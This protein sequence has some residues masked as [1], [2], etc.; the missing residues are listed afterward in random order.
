MVNGEWWCA[1][2]HHHRHFL[3]V[4][5]FQHGWSGTGMTSLDA[6]AGPAGS[7]IIGCWCL[8]GWFIQRPW[9]NV[10]D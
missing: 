8:F 6:P 4:V 10:C 7:S 5:C 9:P 1:A 2:Q 3:K